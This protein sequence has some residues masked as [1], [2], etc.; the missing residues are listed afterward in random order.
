[1]KVWKIEYQ[2][3]YG[4]EEKL[5]QMEKENKQIKEII[6]NSNYAEYEIIYT[7]EDGIEDVGDWED[8]K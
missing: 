5:N 7:I 4:L 2:K 8:I 6:Y 1:M 3:E